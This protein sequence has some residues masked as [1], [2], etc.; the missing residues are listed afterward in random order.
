MLLT[1]DRGFEMGEHGRIG[2]S[3]VYPESLRVPLLLSVPGGAAGRRTDLVQTVDVAASM[4]A[5]AGLPESVLQRA[6]DIIG[7]LTLDG[8]ESNPP[9]V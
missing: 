9:A 8:L 1:A 2:G 5:L 7:T 4:Y 3:Q 6:R